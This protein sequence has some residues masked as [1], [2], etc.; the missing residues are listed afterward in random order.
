MFKKCHRSPNWQPTRKQTINE[1]ILSVWHLMKIHVRE[2]FSARILAALKALGKMQLLAGLEFGE[3]LF[4]HRIQ[5][6][7]LIS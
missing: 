4:V 6:G 5:M 1:L 2:D 3:K 7:N